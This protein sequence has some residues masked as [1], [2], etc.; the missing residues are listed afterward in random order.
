MQPRP[1]RPEPTVPALPVRGG[2]GAI[3][4]ELQVHGEWSRR[5]G[6]ETTR[7]LRERPSTGPAAVLMDLYQLVDP[8]AASLPLWLAA[9]RAASV[10][11]APVQLAL[12]LPGATVLERGLQRLGA[13]RL[14]TFATMPAARA[15]MADR[16]RHDPRSST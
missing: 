2:T 11:R 13:H 4:A 6:M 14:P 9:C 10:R 15:A 3:V 5:L 7:R 8:E 12:C 16:L 1:V